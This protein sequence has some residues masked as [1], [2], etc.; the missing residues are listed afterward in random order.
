MVTP[1]LRGGL[2]GAGVGTSVLLLSTEAFE[3][4]PVWELRPWRAGD[5]IKPFGMKGSRL[6]SDILTD[7]KVSLADKAQVQVLTRNGEILWIPGFR[8]SCHFPVK[9]TDTHY[10]RITS[11]RSLGR[12]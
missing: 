12:G 9:P 6:V 7:A 1:P 8:A 11:E 5:R 10:Y 4:E 3:G 2:G